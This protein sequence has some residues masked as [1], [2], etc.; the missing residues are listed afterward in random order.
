MECLNL[1]L[2]AGPDQPLR[3]FWQTGDG[4]IE[5]LPEAASPE[6]LHALAVAH[7]LARVIAWAPTADCLFTA[8]T[9]SPRQLKQAGNAIGWLLEDQVGDDIENLHL[10]Q[11][12][13]Q[14]GDLVPLLVV[15][16][17]RIEEWLA[18]LRVAG[19]RPAAMLPDLLL[20]PLATS[21]ASREWTLLVGAQQSW[22]R[23]GPWQGA[24][25]E[26]LA[27]ITLLDGALAETDSEDA[28]NLTVLGAD[29]LTVAMLEAWA[30]TRRSGGQTIALVIRADSFGDPADLLRDA[31]T[32]ALLRHSFNLLQGDHAERSQRGI[33]M[34]WRV[35]AAFVAFA[36][37][38]QLLSEWTGYF[39]YHSRAAKTQVAAVQMYKQLFPDEHR[40]V[41]LRKQ[42]E[43]HLQGGGSQNVMLVLLTRLGQG[44]QGSGLQAQRMDFDAEAKS[45]NVDVDAGNLGQLEALKQKLEGQGLGIELSSA[46][47]QGSGVRGRLKITAGAA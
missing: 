29:A 28:L 6:A 24:A 39:Y 11:A 13:Q 46:S 4:R 47:A 25:I 35:A 32:A 44:L 31:D 2:P 21:V 42:M 3:V 20:L 41:S 10:V 23:T 1:F 34:A 30:A 27:L 40:I 26:T 12:P 19:L 9:I 37:C 36:F 18:P 16:D 43:A 33:P 17:A 38:V 7:P 45:L 5:P 22:L 8:I 14:A 15:A